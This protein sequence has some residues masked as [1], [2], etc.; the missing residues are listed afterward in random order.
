MHGITLIHINYSNITASPWTL[1][2][3]YWIQCGCMFCL[4][5]VG[6]Q[7][8]VVDSSFTCCVLFRAS[9]SN[10][11]HSRC[12]GGPYW[13]LR[14]LLLS[15]MRRC[16]WTV[17]LSRSLSL[18]VFFSAC[19]LASYRVGDRSYTVSTNERRFVTVTRRNARC[20]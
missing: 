18:S 3:A 14:L 5:T 11:W 2:S 8:A 20:Y 6:R 17:H 7:K 10:L 19:F 9:L 16:L 1:Y 4:H 13:L 12:N 15:V